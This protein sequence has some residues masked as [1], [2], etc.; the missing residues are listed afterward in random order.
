MAP[1]SLDLEQYLFP[2]HIYPLQLDSSLLYLCS[3]LGPK[4]KNQ[5]L[6]SEGKEVRPFNTTA[7]NVLLAGVGFGTSA[8]IAQAKESH[9]EQGPVLL[10]QGD[11]SS[12]WSVKNHPPSKEEMNNQEKKCNLDRSQISELK[13]SKN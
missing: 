7:L 10:P 8:Y 1:K 5:C 6:V 4:L 9:T 3:N 2:T 13:F 11:T 12:Q